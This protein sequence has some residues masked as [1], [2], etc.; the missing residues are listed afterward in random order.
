MCEVCELEKTD[1]KFFFAT[2]G[3]LCQKHLDLMED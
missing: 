1:A 3:T 2:V